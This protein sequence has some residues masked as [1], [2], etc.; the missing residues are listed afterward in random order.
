MSKAGKL[1][2]RLAVC[3]ILGTFAGVIFGSALS[4]IW[5]PPSVGNAFG[6]P[7]LDFVAVFLGGL[8]F[9]IPFYCVVLLILHNATDSISRRPLTWCV[10]IP[11]ALFA[12][13]L[14]AF[15]P[16]RVGGIFWVALVPL[17]ALFAG[18][19]FC[20]WLRRSPL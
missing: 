1:A 12:A 16:N 14:L 7:L 15:P 3:Q 9:G 17:S 13:A 2:V 8:V 10:A 20:I 6:N 11:A 4:R 18:A 19:A 5:A